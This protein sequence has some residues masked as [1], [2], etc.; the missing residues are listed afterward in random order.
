MAGWGRCDAR[1]LAASRRGG[2][3]RRGGQSG[4]GGGGG[5]GLTPA[6]VHVALR[7]AAIQTQGAHCTIRA[8]YRIVLDTISFH[9]HWRDSTWKRERYGLHVLSVKRISTD[10]R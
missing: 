6:A 5:A 1:S 10:H 9:F 3:G 4:N 2:N 8:S 7:A